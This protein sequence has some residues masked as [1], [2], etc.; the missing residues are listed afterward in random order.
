MVLTNVQILAFFT[1]ANQMALP[2]ATVTKLA[3]KGILSPANLSEFKFKAM[4]R[5]ANSLPRPGGWVID[6]ND[7]NATIPTPPFLFGATW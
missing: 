7:L 4:S 6:T 5:I 2:P 3:E 1:N